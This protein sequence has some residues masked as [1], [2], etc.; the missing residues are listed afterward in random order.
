MS[1]STKSATFAA[2][3]CRSITAVSLGAII[4]RRRCTGFGHGSVL[5]RQPADIVFAKLR[6]GGKEPR[7]LAGVDSLFEPRL[8]S[9][10][11]FGG[12]CS[13]NI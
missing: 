10:A 9:R 5:Q 2:C 1:V 4:A 11:R 3:R 8:Q 6:A 12:S 13:V 7:E